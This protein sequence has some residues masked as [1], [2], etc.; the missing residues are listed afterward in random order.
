M[1]K[2]S[3]KR[4]DPISMLPIKRLIRDLAVCN[5]FLILSVYF[6]KC[7]LHVYMMFMIYVTH[8]L[9]IYMYMMFIIAKGMF[10]KHSS[11]FNYEINQGP[12][13]LY[14]IVLDPTKLFALSLSKS[15]A[16]YKTCI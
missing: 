2:H 3:C 8:A 10:P 5:S 6:H 4:H 12:N 14:C 16:Y 11:F 7:T 1:L 9:H 13:R 15:R